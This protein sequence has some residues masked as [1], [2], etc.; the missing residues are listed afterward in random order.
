M[1]DKNTKITERL[2]IKGA[3]RF[4]GRQFNPP[5]IAPY[6]NNFVQVAY[7]TFVDEY[8]HILDA[9]SNLIVTCKNR[10]DA[11]VSTALRPV[12]D[13]W[14]DQAVALLQLR[15]KPTLTS[16]V[17]QLQEIYGDSITKYRVH[18]LFSDRG[19]I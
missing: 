16:I 2:V 18:Q 6:N 9:D 17:R 5:E 19:L 1:T 7:I 8:I 15:T 13:D 14:E 4:A 12:K 11:P 10:V 3:I